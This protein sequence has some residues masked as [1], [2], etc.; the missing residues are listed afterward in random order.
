[1]PSAWFYTRDG[2]SKSGPVSSAHLQVLAKSGQ[3]RPPDM[4]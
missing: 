3:V 1:M 2:K 4:V